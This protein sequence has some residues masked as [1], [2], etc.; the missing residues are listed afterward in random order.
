MKRQIVAAS[1]M[2]M[3]GASIAQAQ[4]IAPQFTTFGALPQATFGGT[5]IPNDAVAITNATG[6]T[7]GLSASQRCGE[8]VAGDPLTYN[9]GAAVT[10]NGAGTFFAAAGAGNV[11]PSPANPHA[12]WNFNFYVG[13]ANAGGYTYRLFYD[14]DPA[15]NTMIVD[16][17]VLAIPAPTQFGIPL[18]DSYNLGM[19]FLG[20]DFNALGFGVFAPSGGPF[21]PS[22]AGVFTFRLVAYNPFG[23]TILNPCVG[24]CGEVA[25]VSM[26][27]ST[28]PEP[29]T[30]ALMGAGLLALGVAARRRRNA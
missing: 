15:P 19:D 13:G 23:G 27:V 22:V 16:H 6:L 30:Y 5:G 28:V 3:L 24:F 25:S 20:T 12:T 11:T 4:I 2:L 14:F 8:A 1:A 9:C 17:G 21:D 7:L 26:Q 29:S 18:Q 10:N